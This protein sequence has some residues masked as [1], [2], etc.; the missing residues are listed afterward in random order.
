MNSGSFKTFV[1]SGAEQGTRT[2][3]PFSQ[4]HFGAM[5]ALKLVWSAASG[6]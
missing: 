6:N 1:I 2:S 3:Q 5:L 4:N